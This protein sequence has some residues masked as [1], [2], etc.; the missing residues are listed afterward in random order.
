MWPVCIY[1]SVH[2]FVTTCV[3]VCLCECTCHCLD[4]FCVSLRACMLLCRTGFWPRS[5]QGKD[6]VHRSTKDERTTAGEV[7]KIGQL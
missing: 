7:D 5:G 4:R 1:V 6:P 3:L 2:V